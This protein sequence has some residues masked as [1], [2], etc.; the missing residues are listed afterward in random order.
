MQFLLTKESAKD[1]QFYNYFSGDY[2]KNVFEIRKLLKSFP[3]INERCEKLYTS[4]SEC[5][6]LVLL[7]QKFIILNKFAR[8]DI[9][10]MINIKN[11]IFDILPDGTPEIEDISNDYIQK[12]LKI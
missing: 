7:T 4:N 8:S 10:D 9:M 12:L 3:K 2:K 1:I 11:K 5:K 6:E